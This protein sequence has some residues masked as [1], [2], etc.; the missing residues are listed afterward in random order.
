MV[1]RPRLLIPLVTGIFLML[2]SPAFAHVTIDPDEAPKGGFTAVSF[3][4]PNERPDSGTVQLEVEFPADH[5]IPFVSIKP[6][7]GWT[8]NLE[9]TTLP[10]PVEGEG[11]EITEVVSRITWTGGRIGPGEF[12]EFDV[13]MGPL[14][15][16]VDELAFPSIQTYES[17]EV[18]RW[19]EETPPGGEE[20][21]HPVPVLKLTGGSGGGH[22]EGAEGEDATADVDEDDGEDDDSNALAVVALIVG[23]LG[24]VTGIAGVVLGRR[25]TT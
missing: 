13:S 20:P 24:L 21:E 11:E 17:G 25:R 8:A 23:G 9:M 22:E 14:P 3:R 6:K 7:P 18:V 12:D 16:D 19:I 10:E 2:S 1:R 4:V 5:P 15:D